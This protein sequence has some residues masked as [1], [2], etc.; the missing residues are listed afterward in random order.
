MRDHEPA[1]RRFFEAHQ[2]RMNDALGDP[3]KVDISG[4]TS[5]F[6]GYFVGSNPKGVFGGRNGWFLRFMI[7]QGYA[8]YRKIG[9]ERMEVRGLQVTPIDDFHAMARTHWWSCYRRRSGERVEIEFDN[10]YL[11]HV[12][13]SG[14]PKIFAYITG[15]EQQVLKDHGLV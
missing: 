5:A 14:D 8:F 3:P 11:L 4:A 6:A 1:I 9:T 7:P 15:D 10:V 12:P 13:H 2:A